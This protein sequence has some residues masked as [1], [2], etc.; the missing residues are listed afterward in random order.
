MNLLLLE[1]HELSADGHVTLRDG[2]AAHLRTTLHASPGHRARVGIVDG[3]KGTGVVTA[4]EDNA[5][6]LRCAFE[7]ATADVP[8]VDLLLAVPRPK[9]L[10]RLW[11]QLASLGVGRIILTNAARV[12]RPYFDSHVLDAATYRPLLVEGLQQAQDTR[13]PLVSIHRRFRV[14]I[15]D[16]L[17]AL[18]DTQT[19][20]VADPSADRHVR[21]VALVP[22]GRVLLAVGPEGGWSRFELELLARHRFTT[23]GM[24]ARTL[25]SDTACIALL[26]L[27]HDACT[28]VG[29]GPSGIAPSPAV[30]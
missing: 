23:I 25:R 8:P 2:R 5:V 24:G 14:L 10:K 12:E 13:L 11:A 18:S 19:R 29:R 26:T 20:L 17:D 22:D 3:P 7:P 27:V 6:S 9:V 1:L 30:E 15:E 16:E 28:G 4:I 21:D